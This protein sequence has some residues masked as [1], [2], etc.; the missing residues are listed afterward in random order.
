M[1]PGQVGLPAGHNRRVPSLR[2]GEVAA[3]AGLSVEYY[4]RIERG[5]LDGVSEQVLE[6]IARAFAAERRRA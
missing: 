1:T 3:L 2:R 4:T 6:A 5:S